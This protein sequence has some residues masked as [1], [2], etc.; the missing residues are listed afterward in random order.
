MVVVGDMA[1]DGID[2]NEVTEDDRVLSQA[3]HEI[4]NGVFVVNKLLTKLLP[5]AGHGLLQPWAALFETDVARCG[6][7]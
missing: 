2:G 6:Y 7:F 4:G 3:G 1:N 5:G